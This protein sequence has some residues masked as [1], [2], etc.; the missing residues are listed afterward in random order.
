MPLRIRWKSKENIGIALM[1]V[2]GC[3]LSQAMFILI[4]QL[5]LG[6]NNYFVMIIIPIG[7][8]IATF[9]GTIIIYENYAQIRRREKLRSQFQ[10][11]REKN[12]FKKFINFPIT[13]PLLIMSSVFILFFII[14]YLIL[15]IFLEGQLSFVFSET[16]AATIFLLICNVIERYYA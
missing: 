14:F 15:N 6:V 5:F 8:I 4:G 1:L 11:Q 16:L 3:G 10:A 2:G 12:A 9:Y 7:I 13:K